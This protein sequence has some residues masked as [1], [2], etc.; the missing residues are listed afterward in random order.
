[1]SWP[2]PVDCCWH[3]DPLGSCVMWKQCGAECSRVC[4]PSICLKL[5]T[6]SIAISSG[7]N[8]QS[9]SSLQWLSPDLQ[10]CFQHCI[11]VDQTMLSGSVQLHRC[12]SVDQ[13]LPLS[14]SWMQI[15]EGQPAAGAYHHSPGASGDMLRG[16]P[17]A[18]QLGV[19]ISPFTSDAQTDKVLRSKFS[20][21]MRFLLD[22]SCK[23]F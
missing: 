4:S 7:M 13:G 5:D 8:D 6:Y 9:M 16:L 12:V 3:A 15:T 10:S 19:P 17:Q 14:T 22:E 21:I 1:M 2:M 20:G 18:P 23:L 11:C